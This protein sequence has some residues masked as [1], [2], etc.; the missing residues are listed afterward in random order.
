MNALLDT[1]N[2]T[3]GEVVGLLDCA[4]VGC[5]VGCCEGGCCVVD[6]DDGDVGGSVDGDRD[7]CC[8][9]T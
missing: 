9:G 7:G 3:V 8:E 5:S 6:C 2:P 1:P 4:V